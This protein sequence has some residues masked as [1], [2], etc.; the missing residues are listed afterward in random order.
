MAQ[1]RWT[2]QA[3]EDVESIAE[4]ISE[5]SIHYANLFVSDILSAAERL[6]RFPE[7]GRIVPEFNEPSIREIILGNYRIVY[8]LK[9][10]FAEILTVFHGSKLI[11]PSNLDTPHQ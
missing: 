2:V 9:D 8:R 5:D 7:I 4:F 6:K 1:L 10:D 3:V 11:D